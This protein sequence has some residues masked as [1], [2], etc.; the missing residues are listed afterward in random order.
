MDATR[1]SNLLLECYMAKGSRTTCKTVSLQPIQIGQVVIGSQ[2]LKANHSIQQ[3]VDIVTQNQKYNKLVKLLDDIM[4]GSRILIFMDMKKG[5]DQITCQLRMDGPI[6]TATN[7]KDVKYVINYDFP[8]SLEDYVHRIGRTGRVGAKGTAYTFF[9]ATNA[10]FA[11]ELIA[12]L[13]EVGQKVNPDLA[14]I[15]RGA[16]PPPSGSFGR[17]VYR[18]GTLMELVRVLALSFS[19][20][21]KCVKVFV[22]GSMGEGALAGMPLQLACRNKKDFG[23]PNWYGILDPLHWCLKDLDAFTA[24]IVVSIAFSFIPASLVVAIMKT[25]LRAMV[26]R[27]E[28]RRRR[29]KATTIVQGH[30]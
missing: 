30:P 13:Q 25:K 9:T 24:T 17:D 3:H 28:F 27:D 14:A 19:N 29:N 2:D 7:V 10:R 23:I 22:Q 21:G 15:G 16:P 8:G 5:C 26:A 4:D 12:I 18:I 1:L 6:M 20:D 11:K